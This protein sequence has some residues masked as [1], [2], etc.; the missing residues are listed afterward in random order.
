[1]LASV[2]LLP[3]VVYVTATIAERN[4]SALGLLLPAAAIGGVGTGLVLER[5]LALHGPN[6][7]LTWGFLT[8]AK[9]S[10][11]AETAGIYA[12][13]VGTILLMINVALL[14]FPIGVGA[15]IYL[16]EYAPDTRFTRL[17]DVNISNLAGVPSVVYGLLGLG[18]FIRL[19]GLAPGT[20]VVGGMTLALL[21]LPIVIISA[22]EAIRS[23]PE[24]RRKASYGMGA[25]RWQTVRNVVLPEAFPGILTG[26]I[27]ALGRAVGET[28]PLIVIGA[29]AIF[30]VPDSLGDRVGAI[31]L[32]I[33]AWASTFGSP[34]FYTTVLAA[35]VLT[36]VVILL[37]LNSVAIV[38]RNKYQR[39]T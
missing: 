24:T 18:A 30:G 27:L 37:T 17:I 32:Q 1:V 29:P 5:V 13:I 20:V 10:P 3:A 39:D 15:A 16:E 2:G 9:A 38:L 6:A 26:T 7:W 23:V 21:I 25:T 33:Y 28:A 19:G 8:S 22:R 14:A 12:G 4:P 11:P 34:A 31:P 36:I 35:G